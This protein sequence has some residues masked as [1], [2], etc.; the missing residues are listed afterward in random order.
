MSRNIPSSGYA[1][2]A[3]IAIKQLARLPLIS[4][5]AGV[6]KPWDGIHQYNFQV[7][8]VTIGFPPKILGL[9]PELSDSIWRWYSE[10]I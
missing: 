7:L 9:S 2:M 1:Q 5:R 4:T 3:T 8:T 6:A 10:H